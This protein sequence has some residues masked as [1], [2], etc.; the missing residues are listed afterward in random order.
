MMNKSQFV[1]LRGR[2]NREEL[3]VKVRRTSRV[4]YRHFVCVQAVVQFVIVAG[5]KKEDTEIR[6]NETGEEWGRS[7]TRFFKKF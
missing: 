4:S 1:I 6:V 7:T 5:R 3:L 2:K